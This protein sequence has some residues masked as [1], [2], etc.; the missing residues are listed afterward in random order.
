[1][2]KDERIT[3]NY[4]LYFSWYT[5]HVYIFW[6]SILRDI[7]LF[8]KPRCGLQLL[9]RILIKLMVIWSLCKIDGRW[10]L[11]VFNMASYWTLNC[12]DE[13]RL[14]PL[15]HIWPFEWEHEIV[16]Q[17]QTTF[18]KHI[19]GMLISRERNC[20]QCVLSELWTVY[21]FFNFSIFQL[22]IFN[23]LWCVC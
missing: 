12:K 2:I 13:W 9:R 14:I 6:F 16:M 18:L 20:V 3:Q 21:K 1:M 10:G 7:Y 15:I 8:F 4:F 11:C 17:C 19:K 22:F 23:F 5:V